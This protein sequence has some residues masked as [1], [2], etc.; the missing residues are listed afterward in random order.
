MK[1]VTVVLEGRERVL[2]GEVFEDSGVLRVFASKMKTEDAVLKDPATTQLMS[3]CVI[4]FVMRDHFLREMIRT[5]KLMEL[6]TMRGREAVIRRLLDS[7]EE[8]S[9]GDVA[10][11]VGSV[12]ATSVK[13][14]LQSGASCMTLKWD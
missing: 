5:R 4:Y 13:V 14:F 2:L 9:P 10:D 3:K 8:M 12:L 1:K 6:M 7:L 11:A